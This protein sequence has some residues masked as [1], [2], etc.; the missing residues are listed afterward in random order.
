MVVLMIFILKKKKNCTKSTLS[1]ARNNP[2]VHMYIYIYIYIIYS[3]MESITE[4]CLAFFV[5]PN[6]TRFVLQCVQLF[7]VH[8]YIGS[9][10]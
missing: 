8:I 7:Y 9:I 10:S 4:F 3:T 2:E 5:R 6:L 1:F